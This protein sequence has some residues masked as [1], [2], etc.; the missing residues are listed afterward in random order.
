MGERNP[1]DAPDSL[2]KYLAD[3]LPKQDTETLEDVRDFV[4][5]LL[6]YRRGEVPPSDLPDD[7]DPV[8]TDDDGG[9]G[10]LVK[11]KVTCG[12]ETCSC[13]DGGEKHGP[14]LYRYY[15]VDGTVKSEYVGK[16]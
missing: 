5:A 10:T 1:P 12:D 8:D 16:P 11:E 13:M 2:P 3:G 4:D 15:R 9:R 6:D 14:Y 7:A